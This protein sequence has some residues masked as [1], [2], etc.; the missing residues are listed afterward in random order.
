[1]RCAGLDTAWLGLTA[2]FVRCFWFFYVL[3]F[4]TEGTVSGLLVYFEKIGFVL[5]VCSREL[6][7]VERVEVFYVFC[8]LRLAWTLGVSVV[9]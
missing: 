3:Y 6:T 8:C 7:F 1:M 4:L 5:G 2:T 9:G